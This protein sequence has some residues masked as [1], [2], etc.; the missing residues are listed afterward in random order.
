MMKRFIYLSMLILWGCN[1]LLEQTTPLEGDFYI[2]DGWLA[3][4]SEKYDEAEQHFATAIEINNSGS[5]YHCL[6]SIGLGWTDLYQARANK[7][8]TPDGFVQ[9]SGGHFDYARSIFSKDK[10][11]IP[12][13]NDVRNHLYAGLMFQ[14]AYLAKQKAANGISWE[15]T[16]TALDSTVKSLYTESIEFSHELDRSNFVFQY[17]LSL[18]YNEIILL[19]TE[20]YIL[21][22]NITLAIE[23]FKQLGFEQ[24]DFELDADC[25]QD[26]SQITI[27]ECLCLAANHG[28]CPFEQE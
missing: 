13:S 26:V 9:A 23:E 15:T 12:N 2:Q 8:T 24:F 11:S 22:G 18:T 6:A 5:V 7:E 17:D 20:N 16:N 1:T 27:V 25:K 3:F 19:R 28:I 14:R 21:L 10:S 4:S